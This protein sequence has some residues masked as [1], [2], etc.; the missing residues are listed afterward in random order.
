MRFGVPGIA[1]KVCLDAIWSTWDCTQG[2]PGCVIR[3]LEKTLA[4]I[5]TWYSIAFVLARTTQ[6][7]LEIIADHVAER[8]G[9]EI[10]WSTA[11][12]SGRLRPSQDIVLGRTI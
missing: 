8:M 3:Y 2:L 5:V 1:L 4:L 6:L 12:K 9:F 11:R 10:F 7:R